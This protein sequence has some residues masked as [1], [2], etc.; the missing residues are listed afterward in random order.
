MN[1]CALATRKGITTDSQDLTNR[2]STEGMESFAIDIIG[3]IK[4]RP[5]LYYIKGGA[6][7]LQFT[8][9]GTESFNLFAVLVIDII[10]VLRGLNMAYALCLEVGHGEQQ[11]DGQ[12]EFLHKVH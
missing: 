1:P 5:L 2:R 11:D 10:P 7:A 4:G 12:Y 6:I 9:T 8:L 3:N